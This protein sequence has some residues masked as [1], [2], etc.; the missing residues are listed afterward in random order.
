[1]MAGV[2]VHGDGMLIDHFLVNWP[3]GPIDTVGLVPL[4][5]YLSYFAVLG[6]L[7]VRVGG[8]IRRRLLALL[9]VPVAMSFFTASAYAGFVESTWRFYPTPV[10][11]TPW[12]WFGLVGVPVLI[13]G[14][15]VLLVRRKDAQE[16]LLELGRARL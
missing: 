15:G 2:H 16:R 6:W 4:L 1:M 11:L 9:A 13:F 10:M 5:L 7:L 14:V 8:G 12:Q 3:L